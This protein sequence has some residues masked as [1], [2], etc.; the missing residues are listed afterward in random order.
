M[1]KIGRLGL[2]LLAAL[3]FGCLPATAPISDPNPA[4][5]GF[6]EEL[7]KLQGRVD[8][9]YGH[10]LRNQKKLEL[11]VGNLQRTMRDLERGSEL[12]ALR[13]DLVK[14][15]DELDTVRTTIKAPP[16]NDFSGVRTKVNSLE[17]ALKKQ[18]SLE[19]K[20]IKVEEAVKKMGRGEE[21]AA[22]KDNLAQLQNEM[23]SV[24][25]NM[26]SLSERV[27]LVAGEISSQER[28][29]SREGQ[30]LRSEP[31]QKVSVTKDKKEQDLFKIQNGILPRAEKGEAGSNVLLRVYFP[32]RSSEINPQVASR[33]EDLASESLKKDFQLSIVSFVSSSSPPAHEQ[34]AAATRAQ[35]IYAKL[36]AGGVN[37][38]KVSSTIS[39]STEG[40][41]DHKVEIRRAD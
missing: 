26:R 9:I 33:I 1:G 17:R 31:R 13:A 6:G 5:V 3:L 39:A 20:L 32:P 29:D 21:M 28:S 8:Y 41:R 35:I 30:E 22:L 11:Q 7:F 36:L 12:S 23:R 15:R 24:R 25:S 18:D 2:T 37:K 40:W 19:T 10:V 14:L 4:G 16:S 38:K 34:Q 27:T